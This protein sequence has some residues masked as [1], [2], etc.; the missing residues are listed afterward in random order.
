MAANY[1]HI[2]IST[3]RNKTSFLFPVEYQQYR[4]IGEGTVDIHHGCEHNIFMD[5]TPQQAS[6]T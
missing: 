5:R 2:T 6:E 4:Y 1:I 3:S